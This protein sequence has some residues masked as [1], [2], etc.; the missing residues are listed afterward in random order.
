MV[1]NPHGGVYDLS[2]EAA[3]AL[4]ELTN[5]PRMTH[6]E[7]LEVIHQ[8]DV[9]RKRIRQ[10]HTY[11]AE[12]TTP[13][14]SERL[15]SEL[16]DFEAELT[17]LRDSFFYANARLVVTITNEF[18]RM[19]FQDM[20]QFGCIGLMRAIDLYDPSRGAFSTYATY[21]IKQ[22]IQRGCD[23]DETVIR[24]PVHMRAEV[25]KV[26]KKVLAFAQEHGRI[27]TPTEACHMATMPI[28]KLQP[29]LTGMTGVTSLDS[30]S[31][32]NEVC[33]VADSPLDLIVEIDSRQDAILA[34]R[35][36]LHEL[37]LAGMDI[38]ARIIQLRYRIDEP[39]TFR[40]NKQSVRSIREV[41]LMLSNEGIACNT[42]E[43]RMYE[44]SGMEWI[45]TRS[46]SVR[47]FVK[48]DEE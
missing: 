17:R 14:E 8:L 16:A 23:K 24:V 33:A 30:L 21:W 35:A 40:E 42:K 18:S 39:G 1:Q 27:L 47:A 22:A 9:T 10:L 13:E 25:K 34:I 36:G 7:E 6:D 19:S 44:Q 41:H 48:G 38:A 31:I 3:H 26:R 15:H 2:P 20:F 32:D 12:S 11:I 4:N 28:A 46:A 45:A 37:R 43:V 5:Y 29:A